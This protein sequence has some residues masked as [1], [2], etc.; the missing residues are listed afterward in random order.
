MQEFALQHRGENPDPG[1]WKLPRSV[2]VRP[3]EPLGITDLPVQRL[4]RIKR[5]AYSF[6]LMVVGE[7]GLGKT[8]FLNTLFNTQ[9]TEG[10]QQR[11]LA[12]SKTVQI[13]PSTYELVEEG[14]TLMLT[15]IDTPGFG[16]Q[17]NRETN[18]DPI[19]NYIDA[20]YDKYLE[21]ERSQQIRKNIPDSRV[22]ALLYFLPPTG[23]NKLRDLDL[24]FLQR[25]S[26]KVNI[27][28]VIGRADSLS[29]DEIQTYKQ[30]ILRDFGIHDIR[31]YPTHH[32]EDRDF[33]PQVEKYIPFTVIGSDTFVNVN[34]KSVRGRQYRWGSVEVENPEHCDFV[35]LRELLIRTNM[36]DLV[37]TTHIIHYSQYRGIKI[38]G[39]GRPES[40]LACDEYY[41]SRIENAKRSLAEEMQRKEDEM[42][43]RFVGKVRE[44]EQSLRERE[45]ILNNTRQKMMEELEALRRQVEVEE[46][47]VNELVAS[48]GGKSGFLGF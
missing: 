11:N 48:K 29:P 22:H 23:G 36:Q 1:P 28:P 30:A 25:L 37:D 33:V 15:V 26:A 10:K 47:V 16:D 4:R 9:L 21:A 40:F 6:N 46:G 44:K 24:E 17:L 42:R 38:R 8:T 39:K 45:E 31:I 13:K 34:G 14:V 12:A 19:I 3:S 18:F 32:A 27:I 43:Q 41:E 5:Q 2:A 35:H 20:Q 7:S